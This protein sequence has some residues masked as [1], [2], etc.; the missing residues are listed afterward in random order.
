MNVGEY[1]DYENCKCR[2]RLIDKM[3]EECTENTDEVKIA[4][5]VLFERGNECKPPCTI[6]VALIATVFTISIGFG[7]YFI[8]YK[9]I[10]HDKKAALKYD[11][12][13]QA[14]NY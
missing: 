11:Y 8:Y 14:S 3:I 6:Y 10:N 1:L 9:Y 12:V 13:Y 7:T 4:V 5:M 2:K